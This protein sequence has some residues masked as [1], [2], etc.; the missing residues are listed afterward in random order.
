MHL[1]KGQF[2]LLVA[3]EV[4]NFIAFKIIFEKIA[5]VDGHVLEGLFGNTTDANKAGKA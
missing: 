4:G 5:K 2:L 1:T 3:G